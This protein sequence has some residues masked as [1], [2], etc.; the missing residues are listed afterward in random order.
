[1]STGSTIVPRP[2]SITVADLPDDQREGLVLPYGVGGKPDVGIVVRVGLGVELGLEAGD[3]VFYGKGHSHEV[4][5]V[6]VVDQGCV[7]AYDD[8]GR[9]F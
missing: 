3:K 7:I 8:S 4:E 1:M 6:K 5:D 2:G 9:S